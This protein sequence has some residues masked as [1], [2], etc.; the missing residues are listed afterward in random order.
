[1]ESKIASLISWLFQ[2]LW[3]P[4]LAFI[5]IFNSDAYFAIILP[6]ETK[7]AV[8]ITVFISTI[9]IPTTILILL[10][11][12]KVI[13]SLL[14]K[15][16]SQRNVPYVFIILSYYLTYYLLS[17][18]SLPV[19]YNL[20]ILLS[21]LLIIIAFFINFYFKISAHTLSWGS[22]TGVL[23]GISY[24][25]NIDLINL[26]VVLMLISGFV[27]YSRLQLKAHKEIEVYTGF[28][29][30]FGFMVGMFILL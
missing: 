19:I 28:L 4:I 6:F 22:F 5:V 18:T 8:L 12:L 3:V 30:G 15:E 29:L 16:R 20:L 7:L 24:R 2:P 9:V 14:L 26:I 25:Y 21:T 17:R 23:V 1:M 10:K 11:F 27:A 13:D